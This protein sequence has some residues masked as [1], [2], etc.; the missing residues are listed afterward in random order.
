M[1]PIRASHARS[2][3]EGERML[4]LFYAPLAAHVQAI[5]EDIAGEEPLSMAHYGAIM[6]RVDRELSTIYPSAPGGP[7]RLE[8]AIVLFC[9]RA[10]IRAIKANFGPILQRIRRVDPQFV[11]D[12]H[13]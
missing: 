10:R 11:R 1:D 4:K 13:A 8:D 12:L 3:E 6:S 2:V 5:I 7:S 9:N